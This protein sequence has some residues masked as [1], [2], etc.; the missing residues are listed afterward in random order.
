MDRQAVLAA[1]DAQIRRHPE[2]QV[3]GDDRVTRSIRAGTWWTGVTWS[4]L[5]DAD[6]DAVIAA[7]ISRFAELS[8]PWE[9]KHYSHDRP[10][11]LPTACSPPASRPSR[12]RP[13]SSP[14]SQSWR[15][16][17]HRLR[18]WSCTR[19]STSRISGAGAG[20][21]RGLRR[22]PFRPGKAMLAGLA[23]RP[24]PR[25]RGR[26]GRETRRSPRGGWSST[27]A[28]SS[29]ACGAAAP[30]RRGGAAVCSARWWPTEPPWRRPEGSATSRST[31][32][33]QP[34]DPPA[35]RLRRARHHHPVHPPGRIGLEDLVADAAVRG[36]P[37]SRVYQSPLEQVVPLVEAGG[38]GL[39]AEV[40]SGRRHGCSAR[41]SRQGW[42]CVR[43]LS[44]RWRRRPSSPS[45][46]RMKRSALPLVCG[47]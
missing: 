23:R 44:D 2:G 47:R 4:A 6:A 42:R 36:R 25:G 16:R 3:E 15:W 40:L 45:R 35:T 9:W 27:V 17:S 14:R 1:F 29:P 33:R 11:D 22:G 10:A 32:P 28:P 26:L 8:R 41:A 5:D 46:V 20:A 43:G 19:S 37:N 30:W 38:R 31:P 34:A 21:R 18:A 39:V 12:P 7:Q 24:A 13:C